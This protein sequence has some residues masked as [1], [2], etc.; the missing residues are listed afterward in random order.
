[1][2]YV[3]ACPC[4]PYSHHLVVCVCVCSILLQRHGRGLL[5]TLQGNWY[6]GEF[7]GNLKH[8][9]GKMKYHNG[10]VYEGNWKDDMVSSRRKG[11]G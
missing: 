3:C 6:E 7:R 11:G 8:G 9:Q 10:D 1:M 4:V 5:K 2:V